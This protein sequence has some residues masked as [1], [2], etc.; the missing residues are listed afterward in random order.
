MSRAQQ[1]IQAHSPTRPIPDDFVYVRPERFIMGSGPREP[2]RSP[3]EVQRVITLTRGYLI[4]TKPVTQAQWR[5]LMGNDPSCFKGDD[6]P[7]EQ[8]SWYD[9]LAFCNALSE[10]D[11][12]EACYRLVGTRGR[13]G[14]QFACKKAIFKGLDS[15]GYRLPTEAEWEFS[16]RAGNTDARY[17]PLAETSWYDNNSR[18]ETQ[19]VGR[20]EANAWG[21]FDVLG[22]VW[23]WV[24]DRYEPTPPDEEIDPIGPSEGADRV[25]RGGC[26][27]SASKLCRL[28]N[29]GHSPP[30]RH[31]RTTGFRVA[32]TF[33]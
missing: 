16:A 17:G 14:E 32:R 23:E 30:F 8:V 5:E 3:D 6:R 10:R 33:T 24:W 11:G 21:L 20:K 27:N 25:Q 15:D 4:E 13:P 28:G 22:N 12:L 7:V 31:F 29:R 9:A 18:R 2:G 1:L 19:P 26:Y